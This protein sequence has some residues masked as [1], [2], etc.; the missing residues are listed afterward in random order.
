[1]LVIGR[2][3]VPFEGIRRA[4]SAYTVESRNTTGEWQSREQGG[5]R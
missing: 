5:S 4:E 1:M 2:Q 3:T